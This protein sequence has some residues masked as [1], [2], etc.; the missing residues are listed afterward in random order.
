MSVL[1][2]IKAAILEIEKRKP[3]RQIL[4][5]IDGRSGSGKSTLAGQLQKELGGNVFH[6]DDFF[7]RPH[8]RTEERLKETGGNVDYERFDELLKCI[9]SKEEIIYRP[10]DCKRQEVEAGTMIKPQVLNIVEGSYSMHP[11]F[12]D[13]YDLRIAL[14]V[15]K[16]EQRERILARNGEAMFDRFIQE[17]IPKEEAYLH[18]FKI[19]EESRL[20]FH[21]D[22]MEKGRSD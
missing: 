17:W 9:L 3:D 13:I 15:G 12:G 8:Q 16:E 20:V 22:Y 7:L 18:K 5:A 1:K 6:M 21:M 19:Y 11:Y 10:Y 14:D 2:E 4:V